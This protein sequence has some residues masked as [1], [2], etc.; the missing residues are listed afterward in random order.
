MERNRQR[1][2]LAEGSER[3]L[4]RDVSESR[5]SERQEREK[6]SQERRLTRKERAEAR[7]QERR[8]GEMR[9]RGTEQN[10]AL[11]RGLR[12]GPEERLRGRPRGRQETGD[13]GKCRR[14]AG[15][16]DRWREGRRDTGLREGDRR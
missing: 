15:L 14:R 9:A 3:Q 4:E 1:D 11:E 8:G 5:G 7:G 16:R 6:E 2:D 10:M 13:G 12:R